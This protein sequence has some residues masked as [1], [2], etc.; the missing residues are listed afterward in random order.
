MRYREKSTTSIA[1]TSGNLAR[2]T[3]LPCRREG[4]FSSSPWYVV[5]TPHVGDELMPTR[6]RGGPLVLMISRTSLSSFSR[7]QKKS[8][9]SSLS[10]NV[11]G[12]RSLPRKSISGQGRDTTSIPNSLHRASTLSNARRSDSL[13]I[14]LALN[15]GSWIQGQASTYIDRKLRRKDT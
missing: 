12:S 5:S 4:P 15:P 2:K 14:P 10:R 3:P 9:L 6:H 8:F 1:R 11:P 13:V 7:R